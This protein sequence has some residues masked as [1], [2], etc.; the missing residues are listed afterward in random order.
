ML[1][2]TYQQFAAVYASSPDFV[3]PKRGYRA[4]HT[5]YLG[6]AP[7]QT[8]AWGQPPKQ[9]PDWGQ[10]PDSVLQSALEF[11]RIATPPPMCDAIVKEV[12]TGRNHVY[13]P[14]NIG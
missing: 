10:V 12:E 3:A 11:L 1:F 4:H 9:T 5:S 14:R 8:T 13:S 2:S 6:I 7:K